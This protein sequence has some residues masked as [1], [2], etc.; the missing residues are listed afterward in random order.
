M[1]EHKTWKILFKFTV[2]CIVVTYL[3]CFSGPTLTNHS[4]IMN[5]TVIVRVRSAN[6][7]S[8]PANDPSD[9]LPVALPRGHS[10][11]ARSSIQQ[12]AVPLLGAGISGKFGREMRDL[13]HERFST[14]SVRQQC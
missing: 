2:E 7:E 8:N 1:V 12:Q 5:G 6:S 13:P 3:M 10:S 14:L 11:N 4:H 9:S